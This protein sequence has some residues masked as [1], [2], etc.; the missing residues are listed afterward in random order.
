MVQAEGQAVELAHEHS[1]EVSSGQR[2]EFGANW[3]RFLTL[4]DEERIRE[5]E[6]SL[7]EVLGMTRLDQLRFLDIGSGSGLFSLAA[8][9]LGATVHSFDYDPQSVA[10]TQELRRRYFA[11]DDRWVVEQGSVLDRDYMQALGQFDIVYSYG[12]IHH[13]GNM[14]LGLENA[15]YTVADGGKLFLALYNDQGKISH[16]W[17][18]VKRAYNRLPR[19][20]RFL[21]LWPTAVHLW[22]RPIVK[23]FLRGRPFQTWR[24]YKGQRGMSAWHDIVDWVGGYPFEVSK[25]EE[26]FRYYHS[27][28]YTLEWLK[29]DGGSL[30][31]NLFT[32]RKTTPRG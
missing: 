6:R 26:I 12:V 11:Q 14:W 16:R 9:R 20:L 2:F 15:L 23:D 25:P 27:H 18:A 31:C 3:S 21:V 7:Q 30:G 4:L 29:T 28:G 32:F 5:A 24:A 8:R 17:T 1:R 10:C 19:N 13:T 22:W